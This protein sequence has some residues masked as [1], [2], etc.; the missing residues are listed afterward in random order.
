MNSKTALEELWTTWEK[1]VKDLEPFS[2]ERKK[3]VSRITELW[4][5]LGY[6][7]QRLERIPAVRD[8]SQRYFGLDPL[9]ISALNIAQ[10]IENDE[11]NLITLYFQHTHNLILSNILRLRVLPEAARKTQ[12]LQF[13]TTA[14]IASLGKAQYHLD[15]EEQALWQARAKMQIEIGEL[16]EAYGHFLFEESSY[17]AARSF[18][19]DVAAG[20]S[21]QAWVAFSQLLTGM[22]L[23]IHDENKA[24]VVKKSSRIEAQRESLFE[25]CALLLAKKADGKDAKR[26]RRQLRQ[27]LTDLKRLESEIESTLSELSN[28][29]S[30]DPASLVVKKNAEQATTF[31]LTKIS[32]STGDKT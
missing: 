25:S 26:M 19:T 16:R 2:I 9:K 13:F 4:T 22:S 21:R 14:D 28:P 11:F 24:F 27:N 3:A 31:Q 1:E 23:H 29:A 30:S 8:P 17:E 20:T 10:N 7:S 18:S 15:H 32:Q 6:I 12:L 5:D